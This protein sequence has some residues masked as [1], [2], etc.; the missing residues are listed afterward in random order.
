MVARKFIAWK[1][2]IP[3]QEFGTRSYQTF[4][5]EQED[6]RDCSRLCR[7]VFLA[8]AKH[9]D[10]DARGLFTDGLDHDGEL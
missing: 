1:T 7:A 2:L 6:E 8:P 9:F 3:V 5:H 4:E 10:L